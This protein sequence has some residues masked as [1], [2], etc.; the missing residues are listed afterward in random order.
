MDQRHGLGTILLD[1]ETEA[2]AAASLPSRPTMTTRRAGP[3]HGWLKTQEQPQPA[4]VS[5]GKG[6]AQDLIAELA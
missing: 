5:E 6:D 4:E 2:K 1:Q 3:E